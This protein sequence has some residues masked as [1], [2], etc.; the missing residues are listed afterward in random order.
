MGCLVGHLLWMCH[1]GIRTRW[2][3]V[4]CQARHQCMYLPLGLPIS[5]SWPVLQFQLG[6]MTFHRMVKSTLP[7]VEAAQKVIART[8]ILELP[9]HGARTYQL[10]AERTFHLAL[11]KTVHQFQVLRVWQAQL[12]FS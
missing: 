2:S 1:R 10:E 4:S 12:D 6:A 7:L 3:R 8:Q 9:R 5:R 11:A